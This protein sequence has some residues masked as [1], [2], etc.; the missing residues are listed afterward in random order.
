VTTVAQQLIKGPAEV[1]F[2]IMRVSYCVLQVRDVDASLHFYEELLGLR[3]TLRDGDVAYLKGWEERQHHSLVLRKGD[4]PAVERLGFRVR[5]DHDLDLL[6]DWY[7]ERGG[8]VRMGDADLRGMTGRTLRVWDHLGTPLEFYVA[9]ELLP[10]VLQDYHLHRGAPDD[11]A[12]AFPDGQPG[13]H[14]VPA[15]GPLDRH[16]DHDGRTG[17]RRQLDLHPQQLTDQPQ[18]ERALLEPAQADRPG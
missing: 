15:P 10:S 4:T 12:G 5:T 11:P 3:L 16:V 6:A 1:P 7:A 18:L 9:M 8:T 14:P 17:R 2:D 13:N